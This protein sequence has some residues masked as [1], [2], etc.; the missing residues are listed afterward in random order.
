MSSLQD[1]LQR[2]RHCGTTLNWHQKAVSQVILDLFEI[3]WRNQLL[4]L[5][6]FVDHVG[7]ASD[8][9]S[10]VSS[11]PKCINK[12]LHCC[13]RRQLLAYSF[14]LNWIAQKSSLAGHKPKREVRWAFAEISR[15]RR[16]NRKR[17]DA[18]AIINRCQA[19]TDKTVSIKT[20]YTDSSLTFPNTN[21]ILRG[22][23][24]V[25]ADR[26]GSMTHWI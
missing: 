7:H 8:T 6:W 15:A 21:V 23:S 5:P 9:N 18:T 12:V 4:F 10:I 26:T 2:Q 19:R 13:N 25:R 1:L 16:A 20:L 3:V 17:T 24:R 22:E 14:G 11:F